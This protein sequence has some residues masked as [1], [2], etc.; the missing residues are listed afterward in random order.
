MPLFRVADALFLVSFAASLVLGGLVWRSARSPLRTALLLLCGDFAGLTGAA[1]AYHQTGAPVLRAL[2]QMFTVLGPLGALHVTLRFVGRFT[3]L[4]RN[5]TLA[6]L[7]FAGL[8][9]VSLGSATHPGLRRFVESTTFERITEGLVLFAFGSALYLLGVALGRTNDPAERA[10]TRALLAAWAVGSSAALLDLMLPSPFD[11]SGIAPLGSLVAHGL[12]AFAVTRGGLLRVAS[13]AV[14]PVA[15]T[16]F[17]L[18]TLTLVTLVVRD[19]TS[20]ALWVLGSFACAAV[21]FAV[22]ELARAA[23]TEASTRSRFL[24][25]GHMS[26][27]MAHDLKNPLAALLGATELLQTP[28]TLERDELVSFV[29][30]IRAQGLRLERLI[31]RYERLG[32]LELQYQQV[33]VAALAADVVRAQ[34]HRAPALALTQTTTAGVIGFVDEDLLRSVIENVVSNAMD[35]ILG[36]DVVE[37]RN[38]AASAGARQDVRVDVAATDGG[39]VLRVV[40]TGPGMSPREREQALTFGFSTK[41]SGRGL[42]LAF[43]RRVMDAHGGRLSIDSELGRGTTVSLVLPARSAPTR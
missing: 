13:R 17:V 15:L 5:F 31:A 20:I 35:A 39:I 12:L 28:E 14:L 23:S 8:G 3:E 43:A 2:D 27:Q 11:K 32:S 6:A 40:D 10:R 18:A 41:G 16:A 9:L 33:D 4:R 22:V 1:F 25:M 42:G 29:E 21:C 24:T 7:L 34:A 37:G 26:A 38:A 19:R 30:V 36:A